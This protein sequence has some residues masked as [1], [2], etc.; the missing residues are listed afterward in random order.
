MPDTKR[1]R[2]PSYRHHRPSGQAIV[3][4]S[5]KEFYLGKW[6]SEESQQEYQRLVSEWLA[7]GTRPPVGKKGKPQNALTVNQVL[8][9]YWKFAEE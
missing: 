5:G 9:A 7:S 4:L 3:T 8:L 2:V 6:Q 1:V